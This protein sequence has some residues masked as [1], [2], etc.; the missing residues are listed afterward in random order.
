MKCKCSLQG[1]LTLKRFESW[2]KS[3]KDKNLKYLCY[4]MSSNTLKSFI[5]SHEIFLVFTFKTQKLKVFSRLNSQLPLNSSSHSL[6]TVDLLNIL[7]VKASKKTLLLST[8]WI[9]QA[10]TCRIRPWILM[11]QACS[12]IFGAPAK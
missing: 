3:F 12:Y 4:F 11:H 9:S 1:D 6:Q 7:N 5:L 10:E 2:A 8:R